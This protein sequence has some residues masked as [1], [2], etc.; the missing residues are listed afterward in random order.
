MLTWPMP[1]IVPLS[2][3]TRE[4][5]D[6]GGVGGAVLAIGSVVTAAEV[7][8]L[9]GVVDERGGVSLDLAGGA[10]RSVAIRY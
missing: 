5:D 2:S 6:K 7:R 1:W 4:L 3:T 8:M 9:L 10:G